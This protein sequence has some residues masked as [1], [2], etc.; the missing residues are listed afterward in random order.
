MHPIVH[1][2]F[3]VGSPS[4]RLGQANYMKNRFQ[5]FGVTTPIRRQLQRPYLLKENLPRKSEAFHLVRE[6]WQQ[7][8]RELHY[9]AQELVYKYKREF[10]LE[11]IELFDWMAKHNSWWDTIDFIAPK[12]MAEYFLLFPNERDKWINKW[13]VADDFWLQRCAIL[14]QLKYKDKT[15][16]Q[17][18]SS[19]ILKLS[20][21]NEFFIR[22]AIGWILREYARTDAEW[23]RDFVE[24]IALSNLSKREALKHIG[25]GF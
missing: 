4:V 21:S 18:L 22:K 20:H 9:F 19:V 25:K 1:D 23:V 13:L 3:A 10:E 11:D 7:P 5:F 6:L 24:N 14:F 16:V 12:L 2:F 17:L 15:D 8:Q